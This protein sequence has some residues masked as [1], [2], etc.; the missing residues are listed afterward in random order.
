MHGKDE[1][2]SSNPVAILRKHA[3]HLF[4]GGHGDV[5]GN[6]KMKNYSILMY[7]R[8]SKGKKMIVKTT[9]LNGKVRNNLTDVMAECVKEE[10]NKSTVVKTP[11]TTTQIALAASMGTIDSA[12]A[13]AMR[14]LL[15]RSQNAGL[16]VPMMDCEK[17]DRTL[18]I[19][20]K[21]VPKMIEA[22]KADKAK[23]ES[24]ET[25]FDDESIDAST[26]SADDSESKGDE[27]N[28]VPSEE[29]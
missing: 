28:V 4:N 22:G 23:S 19:E 9:R 12:K 13:A 27:W 14:K 20:A 24:S 10:S 21:V 3:V 18:W 29:E 25:T 8:D 6:K 17:K 2:K 5:T 11:M 15:I 1:E 26:E 16:P 7:S